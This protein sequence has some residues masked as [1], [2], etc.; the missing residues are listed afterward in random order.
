MA[1]VR[2]ENVSP[3]YLPS[4][5]RLRRRVDGKGAAGFA[6]SEAEQV[7]LLHTLGSRNEHWRDALTIHVGPAAA[8]ELAGTEGRPGATVLVGDRTAVYHDGMWDVD[9]DIAEASGV[10]KA[11]RW[12]TDLAH[13]VTIRAGDQ[14]IGIRAVR[15]VDLA[16]LLKVAA[17]LP[18]VR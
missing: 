18:S 5:Y 17:S 10:D 6:G 7:T 3:S 9:A 15:S 8:G 13:S 12:R 16:E 4:G 14:V 1:A 11:F 2:T